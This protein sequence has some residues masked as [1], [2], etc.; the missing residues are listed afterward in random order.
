MDMCNGPLFGKM[1]TFSLPI[2]AMNILQ[3]LFN[4][5]NMVV[6]GRFS[7]SKALAAVGATGALINLIV[8]FFMGLSVGTSVVVAQDYGADNPLGVT[9]TVHTSMTVGMIAGV[10]VMILGLVLCRPL[11][12]MMGTPA[13]ILDLSTLYMRIYFIGVPASMIFDFGAGILRAVGDSR[14][15]M[16]YL[17]IAGIVNVILNLFLVIVLHM[18]VGG[19]ACSTVVTQYLATALIVVCLCRSDGAIRFIPR[20]M[21]IDGHKLMQVVKIGLPAGLQ[22]LLFSISNVL[23]QSALNSFGSTMVAAS[24]ASANVE[25]F[26]GTTMNAYYNAAIAFTGQNMGARKFERIGTIAKVCT[27]L[28]FATWIILGGFNMLFARSL[29]SLYTSD[30]E[31]IRLGVL[32]MNVMMV[33]FF[34]CGVMNVFPGLTRGMGY[35]VLPMLCTLVGAC[36]MRIVWLGTFFA[37][38]PTEIMLFTC[39]PITW[40]L[41]GIGQVGSFLYA[42]RQVRKRAAAENKPAVAC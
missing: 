1:L 27:L 18:S 7:G 4:T 9:R 22:S 29:I 13:D 15:P 37:W 2:M 32:R 26:V 28:I 16:Y 41:A 30:P 3:L 8:T 24:S 38:Y 17:V 31:V 25:G 39:Y 33:A 11:L 21:R 23:I 6:V 10:F 19:V 5:T 42:R 36:L 34:T 35:S 12:V 40:A 20:Q 14:H